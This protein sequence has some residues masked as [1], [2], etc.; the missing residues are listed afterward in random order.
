MKQSKNSIHLICNAHLDPVWLWQRDEGIAEALSTFRVAANF[1][2]EYENFVFCHNEVVLYEWVEQYDPKLFKRIQKLVKT[3]RWNIMGGWYLQPDCN[4]ITGESAIRQINLGK[5]YFQEKFGVYPKTAVN[6]DPFG[7]SRGLVQVMSKAGFESYLFMRPKADRCELPAEVFRWQGYDGSEVVGHRLF[8]CYLT[9]RGNACPKLREFIDSDQEH[10]VG[11]VTWGIGNHGGGPSRVDLEQLNK[12]IE[13]NPALDIKHSNPDDFFAELK[14]SGVELPVHNEDLNFFAT[15]CYTSQIRL[16]QQHRKLEGELNLTEKMVA[17]AWLT[18]GHEYPQDKL[19]EA[20]VDLAF[21]EF[22]DILP[23]SGIKGVEDDSL[24]QIAHGREILSRLRTG[25]FFAM[26]QGQKAAKDGDM[27]LFVWNPHPYEVNTVIECEMQL[28][29]QNHNETFFNIEVLDGKKKIKSQIEHEA[30]NLNL[31]WRKKVVFEAKLPPGSIKRYECCPKELPQSEM[32][33]PKLSGNSFIFDN[34]QMSLTI[35]RR[36]GLIDS[37]KSNGKEL[38]RPGAGRVLVMQDNAD[39]WGAETWSYKKRI[40]SFKLMNRD[41][42]TAFAGFGKNK[43]SPLRIIEEGS[44]RTVVEALFK[45]KQSTLRIHYILPKQGTE[46]EL[47]MQLNNQQPNCMYKMSWPFVDKAAECV[48]QDIFG[49]KPIPGTREEKVFSQW[50]AASVDDAALAIICDSGH[51]LD[52]YKGEMRYSLLRS[53]C[54]SAL[55]IG[56]RQLVSE[57][58]A[59]DRVDFGEREFRF[60]VHGGN[61]EKLLPQMDKHTMIFNETPPVMLFYPGGEGEKITSQPLVKLS[62]GPAVMT[63]CQRAADGKN[64][65]VRIFNPTPDCVKTKLNVL[66]NQI[67]ANIKLSPFEF[68]TFKI[69]HVENIIKV[70]SGF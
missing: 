35:N 2:D 26:L 8:G 65:T 14:Q 17:A 25:A 31:D 9:L 20:A 54:Y 63:C 41:E 61:A 12:F 56:D 4:M 44:V 32:S 23:G 28:A 3:G 13:E 69:D 11:A 40:G 53:A 67:T 30:S 1:C 45:Y 36:T 16:K 37:F 5:E 48:A 58:R 46:F 24:Q 43:L 52:F 66:G 60:K 22:H 19:R 29:D 6:F 64:L 62:G 33:V 10:D 59:H 47:R 15:G 51:G 55:P 49:R 7:H 34:G 50:F 39:P 42:A 27:P 68:K 21:S 38:V 57:D 70:L 18:A